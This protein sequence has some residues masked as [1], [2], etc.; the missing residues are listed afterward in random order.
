MQEQRLGR[1]RHVALVGQVGLERLEQLGAVLSVV[2]DEPLDVGVNEQVL[3][4]AR[5]EPLAD[6]VHRV[7]LEQVH[8][9]FGVV[10]RA[11]LERDLRLSV[12]RVD[13]EEVAE[14]VADA[15]L[16]PELVACVC[17]VLEKLLEPMRRRLGDEHDVDV[18]GKDARA[19]EQVHELVDLD[20]R[21]LLPSVGCLAAVEHHHG[22]VAAVAPPQHGEQLG[23]FL[24]AHLVSG[25]ARA[26][27]LLGVALTAVSAVAAVLDVGR[28]QIAH[29]LGKGEVACGM[30]RLVLDNEDVPVDTSVQANRLGHERQ[31]VGLA[32]GNLENP[33]VRVVVDEVELAACHERADDVVGV[34]PRLL[35]VAPLLAHLGE[36]WRVAHVKHVQ[37]CVRIPKRPLRDLADLCDDL[38]AGAALQEHVAQVVFPLVIVLEQVEHAIEHVDRVDLGRN[39]QAVDAARRLGVADPDE[40]L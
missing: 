29:R 34:T 31:R 27:Q 38:L 33:R 23:A 5:V 25:K 10:A 36:L 2:V 21:R 3:V 14:L 30:S 37:R 9:R 16:P 35:L 4:D 39:P 8:A 20:L 28:D 7:V 17:H 26:Q 22:K 12:L 6:V 19:G 11:L 40:P 32:A 13:A 18:V 15:C 1:L 24:L